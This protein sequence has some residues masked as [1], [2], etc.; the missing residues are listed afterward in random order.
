MP[1]CAVFLRHRFAQVL[2][3]YEATCTGTYCIQVLVVSF[4]VGLL[5]LEVVMNAWDG[6]GNG[7]WGHE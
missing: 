4:F 5:A 7:E 6:S 1:F 3:A 2:L